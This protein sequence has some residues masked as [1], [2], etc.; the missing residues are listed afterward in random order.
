M[1][2]KQI[3]EDLD[4]QIV[5]NVHV[6]DTRKNGGVQ[7]AS[8]GR[9]HIA[10]G[11]NFNDPMYTLAAAFNEALKR[12]NSVQP[13]KE[14]DPKSMAPTQL[15]KWGQRRFL[16]AKFARK[17]YNFGMMNVYAKWL[18]QGKPLNMWQCAVIINYADWIR[19]WIANQE[20]K[21]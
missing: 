8:K 14:I 9:V 19:N 17:Y 21:P 13:V 12:A 6:R 15:D 18:R 3:E 4:I 5:N 20:K 1:K 2:R 10:Y 7:S 16:A 11:G